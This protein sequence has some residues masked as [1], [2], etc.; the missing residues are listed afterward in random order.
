MWSCVQK[1]FPTR[2]H[3]ACLRES[4]STF[5]TLTVFTLLCCLLVS[6]QERPTPSPDKKASEFF[7]NITVLKGIPSDQLIPSMQFMTSSMGVQ[8]EYC[9]VENA[10]DKDDKKPK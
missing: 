8:C 7:K 1:F 3:A 10:F 9:H 6:A 4:R 5:V 2:A